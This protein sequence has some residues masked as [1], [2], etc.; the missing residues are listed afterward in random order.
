VRFLRRLGFGATE[1]TL[2]PPLVRPSALLVPKPHRPERIVV[3]D[4]ETT[5]LYAGGHDR[6]IEIALVTLDQHANPVDEWVTLVNPRRDLGPTSIHGLTGRHVAPAPAFADIVGDA[7]ERIHGAVVVGHNVRFDLAFLQA[8]CARAG[9]PLPEMEGLCTMSLGARL[10]PRMGRSLADCCTNFAIPLVDH[11]TALGDARATAALIRACMNQCDRMGET[12][13]WPTPLSL[14]GTSR[15]N[16]SGRTHHR[17]AAALGAADLSLSELASRLPTATAAADSGPEAVAAYTQLLDRVLEDQRLTSGELEALTDLARQWRLSGEEVAD[18]HRAY[19]TSLV[20]LAWADGVLSQHEQSD[21]QQ[22]ANLLGL[23]EELEQLLR[24]AHAGE[25]LDLPVENRREEL[26]GQSICFT[27]ESVCCL[28][29][30]PL[31]R[32]TQELLAARA[33]LVVLPRVTKKLNLLVLADP[34]SLSG[35]AQTAARYGVRRVAE[36]VFWRTLGLTM[37]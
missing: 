8:E 25:L 35:K 32:A 37:D 3:L 10:R 6:I 12:I 15:P 17:E 20:S 19:L 11:H 13:D 34:D 5:G 29:G 24:A 18:L 16:P 4:V 7:L 36:P 26:A 2:P 9:I 28:Q 23:A 30:R 14:S 31:D 21:L 27:G 33:G 22:F 1:S